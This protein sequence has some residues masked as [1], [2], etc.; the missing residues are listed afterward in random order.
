MAVKTM[1]PSLDDEAK[2]TACTHFAKFVLRRLWKENKVVKLV[3]IMSEELNCW[4][5]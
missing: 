2:E 1:T 3:W 5:R 4:E